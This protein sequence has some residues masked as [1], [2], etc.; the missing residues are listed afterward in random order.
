MTTVNIPLHEKEALSYDEVEALGYCSK[1]QL[2]RLVMLGRVK[3][4]VLRPGPQAVKFL[5]GI[6]IEE[7]R[8]RDRGGRR[9]RA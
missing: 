4:A 9:K 5:R 1:R 7:L 3:R 2:R 6:L 8:E